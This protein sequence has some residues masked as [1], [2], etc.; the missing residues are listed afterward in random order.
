MSIADSVRRASTK[1]RGTFLS[2]VNSGLHPHGLNPLTFLTIYKSVV[3]PKALYGCELWSSLSLANIT[4][5]ECS[6]RFCLLNLYK[7]Y[8][9]L[10]IMTLSWLPV[11]FH[12]L[13]QK[14]T[15]ESCSS[16]DNCVDYRIDMFQ[17]KFLLTD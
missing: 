6:H 5:L 12:Q 14:L 1:L 3:L 7:K 11:V 17:S 2:L 15:T 10:Q 9:Y 4:Q 16:L 8:L 13:K